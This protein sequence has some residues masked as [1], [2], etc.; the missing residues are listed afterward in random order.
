MGIRSRSDPKFSPT[1]FTPA[2]G[3]SASEYAAGVDAAG[4]YLHE[5]N[6]PDDFDWFVSVDRRSIAQLSP[7]VSTP[8]DRRS[9]GG[10]GAIGEDATRGVPTGIQIYEG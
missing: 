10:R 6:S 1:V 4:V 7:T 2:V 3:L 8:T 5:P 9:S